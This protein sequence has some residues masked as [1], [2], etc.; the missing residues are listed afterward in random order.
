MDRCAICS[1]LIRTR[2]RAGASRRAGP[3]SGMPGPDV[4]VDVGVGGW[5]LGAF[6]APAEVR[7]RRGGRR[8][9]RVCARRPWEGA[10]GHQ[11]AR[12]RCASTA[13]S[14]RCLPP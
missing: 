8:G 1:G 11:R 14:A 13:S 2:Y 4:D 12:C 5:Q 6:D 7:D 3:A 10:D 9:E